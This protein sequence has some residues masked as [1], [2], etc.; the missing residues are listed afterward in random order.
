MTHDASAD[1]TW[2][3]VT[4]PVDVDLFAVT[5][6]DETPVAVGGGGTIAAERSGGWEPVVEDGPGGNERTLRAVDATDD[7]RR[8]WVAGASGAIGVYDRR[9]E[10]LFDYSHAE[11]SSDSWTAVA[12]TGPAGGESVLVANG[13]GTVLPIEIDGREPTYGTPATPGSGT[14]ITALTYAVDGIGYAVDASG[15]VFE[16]AVDGWTAS[17][18]EAASTSLRD[19]AVGPDDSVYVAAANGTLYRRDP[20]AA[21]WTAV[22]V[23]ASALRAVDVFDG[24]V[25]VLADGNAVLRRPLSGR[26]RWRSETL[27][28]GDD[29]VDLALDGPDVAVGKSGTVVERPAADDAVTPASTPAPSGQD[30]RSGATCDQLRAELIGRLGREE[31]VAA[32]SRHEACDSELPEHLGAATERAASDCCRQSDAVSTLAVPMTGVRCAPARRSDSHTECT[33]ECGRSTRTA[34]GSDCHLDLNR[35]LLVPLTDRTTEDC[36]NTGF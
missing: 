10:R 11:D 20:A 2:K 21:E 29:V 4:T 18:V 26:D 24:H 8:V 7:G 6:T 33:C 5:Q 30:S 28:A 22:E 1:G 23:P 9:R 14:A 34:E 3:S 12:A 31:L 27:P 19:V 36:P 17:G 15:T 25:A 13:S 16:E 32:L 35:R